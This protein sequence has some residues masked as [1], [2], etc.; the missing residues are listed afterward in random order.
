MPR[1]LALALTLALALLAGCGDS[2]KKDTTDTGQ[3]GGAPA[4]HVEVPKL[5]ATFVAAAH[6]RPRDFP[7][8][9][10]RT[11]EQV[12]SQLR[13]GPQIGLATDVYTPGINRLAFGVLDAQNRFVYAPS[14]VYV[15]QSPKK[16]A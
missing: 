12:A 5:P 4:R 8:T 2:K 1:A 11:L 7:K 9:G 10:G 3:Q 16:P 14:A 6:P 13:P 15:A